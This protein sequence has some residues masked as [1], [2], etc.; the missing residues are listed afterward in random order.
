MKTSAT[1]DAPAPV[2]SEETTAEEETTLIEEE[3]EALD[4]LPAETVRVIS[5]N[6]DADQTNFSTRAAGLSEVLMAYDPDSIG[7]QESR[8]AWPAKLAELWGDTYARVGIAGDGKEESGVQFATYVYY[9]KDKFKVVATGTLWLTPTPEVPSKYNEIVDVNRTCTWVIL[10][11]KTTG[12]RYVHVNAHLDWMDMQVANPNQ[13]RMIQQLILKFEGMGLPVFATAD[14]NAVQGGASYRIMMANEK[15]GDARFLAT[16][17]D[18]T[19]PTTYHNNGKVKNELIDFCFVTK[20]KMQVNTY[21]ILKEQPQSMVDAG[22]SYYSDHYSLFIE[23]TV[24]SLP[25]SL[26]N[27]ELPQIESDIT[28]TASTTEE[29]KIMLT[30]PQ[31]KDGTAPVLKYQILTRHADGKSFETAYASANLYSL[32]QEEIVTVSLNAPNETGFYYTVKAIDVL[33]NASQRYSSTIVGEYPEVITEEETTT[34]EETTAAE[35]NTTVAETTVAEEET[36]VAE[37]TTAAT[38]VVTQE[39]SAT[40]IVTAE[41][42][43][44]EAATAATGEES[45]ADGE[46]ITEADTAAPAKK[47]GCGSVSAGT[48]AVMT[49]LLALAGYGLKKKED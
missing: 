14:Y 27:I 15:I 23:A 20:D 6:L 10:E 25:N 29:G 40:E 21:K 42:T 8:G 5:C 33:G 16:D 7:V 9:K 32:D 18:T 48:A 35:E 1:Y 37:E 45:T 17:T 3:T 38:E 12:F 30:I 44:T 36:T 13:M 24:Q 46:T 34:A 26:K 11:N 4:M 41:E 47:S 2:I 39:E 31:A 28:F 22:V 43:T 19:S 49:A